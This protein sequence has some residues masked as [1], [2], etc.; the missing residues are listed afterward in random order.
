MYCKETIWENIEYVDVDLIG[1]F[2]IVKEGQLRKCVNLVENLIGTFCI[3]KGPT[4]GKLVSKLSNLIGTF[5]IVKLFF[6]FN[7]VAI[8]EI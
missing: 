1:T 7:E 4:F 5:C 8:I 2:C 6:V 3:V